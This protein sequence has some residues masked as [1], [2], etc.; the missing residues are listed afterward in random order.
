MKNS[1]ILRRAYGR[2]QDEDLSYAYVCVA[3]NPR[4]CCT[5]AEQ[6]L[7][8]WVLDLI[9][10]CYTLEDWME[11]QIGRPLKPSGWADEPAPD[12]IKMR[13]TRLA[14]INWMI[15]YWEARGQ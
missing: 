14:W 15:E 13:V 4:G 6:D 9:P 11:E 12:E 2:I 3:I 8:D 5:A 7:R 10:G 1:D